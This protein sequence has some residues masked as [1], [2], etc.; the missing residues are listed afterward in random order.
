M[1]KPRWT[2]ERLMR[3][4]METVD[5]ALMLVD[6][7]GDVLFFNRV[8]AERLARGGIAA[9]AR[10]DDREWPL[11]RS[12]GVTPF[13]P[14]DT[15]L[16]RALRGELVR[17]EELV[18]RDDDG[19]PSRRLVVT[20][21]PIR[22]DDGAVAAMLAW[23]DS[24]EQWQAAQADRAAL[25]R[26]GQLLDGA[27]DY[28][29]LMLG[30]DG[31]VITWSR[32]AEQLTGYTECEMVGRSFEVLFTD[33][34]RDAGVPAAILRMAAETGRAETG[35]MR[36]GKGGKVFWVSGVVTAS[37]DDI[38]RVTGFVKV[39]H[40]VSRQR[41]AERSIMQLNEELRR[42]NEQ[43]EHRVVERTA[44][45]E[46][47]TAD[48]LTAVAELEA[49]SYSVSH[50]LRAPLRAMHGF[51]RLLGEEYIDQLPLGA[52]QY[53]AKI[54]ENAR[55]MGT[56][57]DALLSLSRMQRQGLAVQP[58]DM[59][60]IVAGCW[61]DLSGAREGRELEL[62]VDDLPVCEAD[63]RLIRQV[64]INLLDNAIKYTLGR[65]PGRIRI[66]ATTRDDVPGYLVTDNGAGF[67]MR[68]SNK[69]FQVFQRLHP[70]EDY[71]GDGIGLAVVRRIIHRHGGEVWAMGEVD[72]GATFGFTLSGRST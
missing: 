10:V 39:A 68:Y 44:Q 28:A 66:S 41:S 11:F 42:L 36:V 64:W 8:A 59:G 55:Q 48:L 3:A 19:S 46:R 14:G 2:F 65:T 29:I 13:P 23:Y 7:D 17:N 45:L 38:G 20:A 31:E 21:Q 25:V 71:A 1:R 5:Y 6:A 9:D 26:F 72:R 22:L 27:S 37:R 4:L 58:L 40:D 34:D 70:A 15:P 33:A 47:Q 16:R 63:Q 67:D 49:F 32:S 57:I 18:I 35:G 43:L 50:D 53:L 12:D 69:L 62:Q 51:A 56:L 54:E 24:T 52:A 60:E 61:A 30:P